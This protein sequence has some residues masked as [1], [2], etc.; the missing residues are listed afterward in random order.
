[1]TSDD[2]ADRTADAYGTNYERLQQAKARY[3]PDNLFR[4]N[5]NVPRAS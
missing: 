2:D 5:R 4:V 3:D 1:M